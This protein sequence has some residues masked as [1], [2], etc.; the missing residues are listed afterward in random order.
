[1]RLL[2]I[3]EAVVGS[4][5]CTEFTNCRDCLDG[6]ETEVSCFWCP[7][8]NECLSGANATDFGT[9]ACPHFLVYDFECTQC[10]ALATCDACTSPNARAILDGNPELDCVW[11][12]SATSLVSVLDATGEVSSSK[13]LTGPMC[14]R[15]NIWFGGFGKAQGFFVPNSSDVVQT[16]IISTGTYFVA[17]GVSGLALLLIIIIIIIIIPVRCFVTSL[18]LYCRSVLCCSGWRRKNREKKAK[19]QADEETSGQADVVIKA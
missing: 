4:L 6:Q 17:C 15:G 12:E 3:L 7:G 5:A 10:E 16:Q 18:F 2:L 14:N 11:F 9:E 1:M 13:E 19:T 8:I